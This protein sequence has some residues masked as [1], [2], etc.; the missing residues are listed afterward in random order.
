[1]LGFNAFKQK[2]DYAK[3]EGLSISSEVEEAVE[4]Y[5]RKAEE[6]ERLCLEQEARER[7]EKSNQKVSA[8]QR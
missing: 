7:H 1:M 2:L 6:A 3:R 4:E 5:Q 8:K